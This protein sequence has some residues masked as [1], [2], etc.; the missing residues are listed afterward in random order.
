MI[1]PSISRT[2]HPKVRRIVWASPH[3][4]MICMPAALRLSLRL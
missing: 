4:P 2:A 3:M 1:L